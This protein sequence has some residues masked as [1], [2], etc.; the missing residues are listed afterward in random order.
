MAILVTVENR[1]QTAPGYER[2]LAMLAPSL[3]QAPGL[4]LHG[5]HATADGWR[6][7]EVWQTKLDSDHFFATFVAPHLPPGVRSK[8]AVQCLHS[9][10]LP[11]A[12]AAA[13]R[14]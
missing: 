13:S 2:M 8:R 4:I 6:V 11:A 12:P 1:D 9:V 7:V 3:R 10:V 14:P 5:A